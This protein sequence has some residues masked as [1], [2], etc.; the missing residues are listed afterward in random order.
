MNVEP[1]ETPKSPIDIATEDLYKSPL[2]SGSA[3]SF[4]NFMNFEIFACSSYS[5]GVFMNSD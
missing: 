5:T 3:S 4:F 2:E 1:P